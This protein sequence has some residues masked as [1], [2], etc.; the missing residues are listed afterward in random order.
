MKAEAKIFREPKQKAKK[1]RHT[2]RQDREQY[3]S[4]LNYLYYKCHSKA[5]NDD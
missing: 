4:N 1:K 2:K 5:H 3:L